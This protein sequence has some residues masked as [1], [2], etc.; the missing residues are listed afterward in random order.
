M[1]ELDSGSHRRIRGGESG[2]TECSYTSG[3]S[4]SDKTRSREDGNVTA[5]HSGSSVVSSHLM[6]ER[7]LQACL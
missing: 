2:V 3:L 6:N 5:S 7:C 4:Q 1:V